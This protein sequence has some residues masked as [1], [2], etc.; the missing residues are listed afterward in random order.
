M[1]RTVGG[2]RPTGLAGSTQVASSR[3]RG[4][5]VADRRTA[6]EG[7]GGPALQ[8]RCVA[9]AE[10]AH[11]AQNHEGLDADHHRESVHEAVEVVGRDAIF[12]RGHCVS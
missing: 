1:T 2:S 10:P 8:V 9:G 5:L 12:E 3:S 4:R 6:E 11:V 7:S